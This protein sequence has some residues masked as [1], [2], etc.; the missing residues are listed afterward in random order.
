MDWQATPEYA[1]RTVYSMPLWSMAS[2][3]EQSAQLA[4]FDEVM[5]L[6]DHLLDGGF[7]SWMLEAAALAG[8]A[9]RTRVA[10]RALDAVVCGT[11]G[12]QA[13]LNRL[14]GLLPA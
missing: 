5:T 2:K 7:G 8:P 12:S 11:V 10:P 4:A 6:E 9:L 3:S 1:D 13:M 14:G